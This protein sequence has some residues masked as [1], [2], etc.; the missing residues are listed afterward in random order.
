MH[1]LCTFSAHM[2]VFF[3]T[4]SQKK[5][6]GLPYKLQVT[7][8]IYYFSRDICLYVSQRFEVLLEVYEGL[9]LFHL[10]KA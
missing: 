10:F 1:Y 7:E 9:L 3:G 6:V 2:C 8:L 4:Y 5:I